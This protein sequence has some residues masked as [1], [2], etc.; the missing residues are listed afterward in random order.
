MYLVYKPYT[1]AA[2]D[3]TSLTATVDPGGDVTEIDEDNNSLTIMA[4][5]SALQGTVWGTVKSLYR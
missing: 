5:P 1:A 3:F 2:D 4:G